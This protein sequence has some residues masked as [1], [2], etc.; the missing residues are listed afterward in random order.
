MYSCNLIILS[1][2]LSSII[3]NTFCGYSCD[4]SGVVDLY[5]T[6]ASIKLDERYNE[7]NSLSRLFNIKG[8]LKTLENQISIDGSLSTSLLAI[9]YT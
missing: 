4:S 3:Q 6:R 2:R 8:I 5:E 7:Y 9:N 1:H